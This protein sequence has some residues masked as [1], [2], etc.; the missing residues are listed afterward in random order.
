[1]GGDTSTTNTSTTLRHRDGTRIAL[2]R[3]IDPMGRPRLDRLVARAANGDVLWR[4]DDIDSNP[5]EGLGAARAF[6]VNGW[7]HATSGAIAMAECDLYLVLHRDDE[8]GA[9][10][11][12]ID[13]C[14]GTR[15]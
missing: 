15:R 5:L 1:M 4:I 13:P 12:A 14:S 8:T 11:C 2:E 7:A 6:Y 9:I 3:S 10:V